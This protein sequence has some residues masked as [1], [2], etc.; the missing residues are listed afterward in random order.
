M[1]VKMNVPEPTRGRLTKRTI[2][3][4][5]HPSTGQTFVRDG[6]LRGFALRVTPGSKSFVL[7]KQIHGRV[8]RMTLGQYGVLTVEQARKLALEKLGAIAGGLDPAQ[9]QRHRRQELTFGEL[10]HLY[11]ERHGAYKKSVHND[12]SILNHHLAPWR[13]RKLRAI[14]RGDVGRLHADLGQAGHPTWANRIVSLIRLM[15]NRAEEWGV[16]AG[17]NPGKGIRFFREVKRDRFV[18]PEELPRLFAALR[19]ERN[20]YIQAA[21]LV[22]LLTGAR[23]SE[24]LNMQWTQIDFV[25]AVWRI[26]DTKAGRPHLLPLPK[27]VIELVRS[28]PRQ[29]GNPYVFCGHRTGRPLV[30]VS[31]P[32]KRIR[33]RTGLQDVRVHDLRLTLGSWLAVSGASLPLIGKVL[34]HTNP[35]TTAIY[36]RL[37]LNPVRAALE[38]NAEKMLSFDGFE[39][40]RLPPF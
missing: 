9:E 16:Y 7:E 18:L 19:E 1:E 33:D 13:T 21:L 35:S 31:K 32:W 26:P 3:A 20:I 8:R 2:D 10:E 40:M 23:R 15:F 6:E 38:M 14:S 29:D 12:Q 39:A 5:P 28:L 30:N 37:H 34:N 36:S 17:P 4:M 11:L 22:A 25:Q 27:P 24:V